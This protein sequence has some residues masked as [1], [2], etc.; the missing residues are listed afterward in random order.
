M[1]GE[2]ISVR[3][4]ARRLGIQP[5]TLYD[6]LGRADYGLLELHGEKV[7]I[8]YFQ[9]GAQGQ[10]RIRIAAA[11]VERL[12]E[13]MRVRPRVAPI[14]RSPIPRREFPGIVVPLGRPGTSLT[15]IEEASSKRTTKK[16]SKNFSDGAAAE[17]PQ[18][19]VDP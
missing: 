12:R 14:R 4:G 1:D 2:Y 16:K 17:F 8:D 3:E 19:F 10:G 11:E 13:L 15:M 18:G 9:T 5:A 6:W 7:A